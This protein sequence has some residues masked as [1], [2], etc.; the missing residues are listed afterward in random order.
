MHARA[1]VTLPVDSH[2]CPRGRD[3]PMHAR[4]YVPAFPCHGP[5]AWWVLPASDADLGGLLNKLHALGPAVDWTAVVTAHDDAVTFFATA[6]E[7]VMGEIKTAMLHTR[8]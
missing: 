3:T 7:T 4:A 8:Y 1:A 2:A 5:H 6:G